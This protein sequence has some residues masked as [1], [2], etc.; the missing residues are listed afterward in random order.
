MKFDVAILH[1]LL[2]LSKAGNEDPQSKIYAQA[3][4]FNEQH[5]K[6]VNTIL[7]L[8]TKTKKYYYTQKVFINKS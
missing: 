6:K 5:N 1:G 2:L 4:K 3:S 8:S 7:L